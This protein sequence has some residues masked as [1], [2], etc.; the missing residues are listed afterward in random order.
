MSRSEFEPVAVVGGGYVGLVTAAG[1]AELGHEV[2]CLEADADKVASLARGRVPFF[3][4]GLEQALAKHR[5]RIHFSTEPAAAVGACGL[6]FVCVGTPRSQTGEADLDAVYTVVD[7]LPLGAGQ[8]IVMKSTV[9]PGTGIECRKRLDGQGREEVGYV[10]CPEF[11]RE[12]SGLSDFIKP[13]R[14]VIGD[15]GNGA[16]DAVE[17][18]Y[19]RIT[20][21]DRI[22]RTDLTSAETLKLASNAFLATKIT[23][24]NEIANL[25]DRAGA[26]VTTVA[27]GMGMDPRIGFSCL[28]AG[29]GF[30]GSCFGKDV[31]AL[32]HEF[33]RHGSDTEILDAVLRSN[34]RQWRRVLDKLVEG[35]GS[36]EGASVAVLGL[37]FKPNTSNTRDATSLRVLK[38]LRAEGVDVRAFDPEVRREA[39]VHDVNADATLREVTFAA[40][41]G[42]CVAGAD[43]VVLVTE[44]P[45]FVDLDWSEVR[46]AMAGRLVVDGRNALDPT[47]VSAAGLDYVGVGRPA[48]RPE[49]MP[50]S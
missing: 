9:P 38:G 34:E 12:S 39:L 33:E 40:S 4:P 26:D 1:F 23:F 35:L 3:E 37:A 13:D 21:Q 49:R 15:A 44:W 7:D 43:A 11:L 42:E 27:E 30:G 10:S 24:I 50:V 45:E 14:V 6:F 22:L 2:H 46:R 41:T 17:E 48:S 36:L 20:S 47:A 32:A 18:I 19:L 5:D 8:T 16:G 25:C 31:T 29:I 28:R